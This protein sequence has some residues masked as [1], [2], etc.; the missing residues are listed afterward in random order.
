M[1]GQNHELL[2]PPGDVPEIQRGN[3]FSL[4]E[5]DPVAAH[6]TECYW[7]Q[8]SPNGMWEV[9]RLSNAAYVYR[10]KISGWAIVAKYYSVKTGD[11]AEKYAKREYSITESALNTQFGRHGM[12]ALKPYGVWRGLLILE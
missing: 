11:T 12:R 1:T 2:Y 9:A 4:L 8:R 6:I 7:D 3:W 5:D 10:E